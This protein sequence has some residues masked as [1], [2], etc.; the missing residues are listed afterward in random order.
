MYESRAYKT[1]TKEIMKEI[2]KYNAS[3]QDKI[4]MKDIT[5]EENPLLLKGT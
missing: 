5:E 3:R 1:S 2:Q 4:I